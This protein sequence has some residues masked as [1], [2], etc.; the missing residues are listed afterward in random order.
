MES[1]EV[2][3]CLVE[4]TEMVF[5]LSHLCPAWTLPTQLKEKKSP[6]DRAPGEWP[7]LSLV[8]RLSLQNHMCSPRDAQRYSHYLGL[9][10]VSGSMPDSP[11]FAAYPAA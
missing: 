6:C 9:L 3:A 8:P 4:R 1:S 10:S 5:P 2:G 11:R 7:P